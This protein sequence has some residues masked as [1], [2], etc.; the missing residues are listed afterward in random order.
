MQHA[1]N[2][3]MVEERLKRVDT[4]Q[5]AKDYGSL[6]ARDQLRGLMR[7][8]EEAEDLA[9]RFN[10]MADEEMQDLLDRISNRLD[11]MLDEASSQEQ[12]ELLKPGFIVEYTE[13]ITELALSQ[14]YSLDDVSLFFEM[15]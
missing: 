13:D 12:F 8:S 9:E 2:L 3:W 11:E 10:A 6:H 7:S 15:V 14:A 4:L 1:E 5:K